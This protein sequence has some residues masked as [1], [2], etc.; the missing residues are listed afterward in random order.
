MPAG[1]VR[2]HAAASNRFSADAESRVAH[3]RRNRFDHAWLAVGIAVPGDQKN[4]DLFIRARGGRMEPDAA[5][6]VLLCDRCSRL[7]TVMPA[8]RVDRDECD[9]AEIG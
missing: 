7:E 2:R 8:V 5:G 1:R 9:Y 6:G 3:G 4:L